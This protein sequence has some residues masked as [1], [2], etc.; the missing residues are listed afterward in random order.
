MTKLSQFLMA[1][2]SAETYVLATDLA[3]YLAAGWKIKGLKYSEGGEAGDTDSLFLMKGGSD[4]IRVKAAE[5]QGYLA[6]GYKLTDVQYGAGQVAVSG[7][8]GFLQYLDIPAFDS[9]EV[10]TVAATKVAVSFTTEI[11][12]SDYAAGVVIEVDEVAAE[13]SAAERQS[14]LKTVHYTIAAVANGED[15]TFSYDED[16]G[17]IVSAN[18]GWPLDA[19]DAEEVTNNVPSE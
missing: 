3:A 14:D 7:S 5:V 18:D 6:N 12:A 17:N 9:A 19:V 13:I 1:R 16:A 4:A 2:E 15:V 8:A 11:S 10:G